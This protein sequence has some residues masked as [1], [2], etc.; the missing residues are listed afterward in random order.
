MCS[1]RVYASN[2]GEKIFIFSESFG[3]HYMLH[4][5]PLDKSLKIRFSTEMMEMLERLAAERGPGTRLA[6]LVREAVHH[7]YAEDTTPHKKIAKKPK[8]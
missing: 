2:A 5:Q 7:Y 3:V 8:K 6:D 4:M 1:N